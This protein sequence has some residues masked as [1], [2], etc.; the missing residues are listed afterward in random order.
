MAKSRKRPPSA[1]KLKGGVG[2]APA[3][4]GRFTL[5][6]WAAADALLPKT[7]QLY[8]VAFFGEHRVRF[9]RMLWRP[10]RL[11]VAVKL[12]AAVGDHGAIGRRWTRL[13]AWKLSHRTQTGL[14]HEL[15]AMR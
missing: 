3:G 9:V 4:R 5:L 8:L 7:D 15:F 10:L 14:D 11:V 1:G 2:D 13:A 12:L 6:R